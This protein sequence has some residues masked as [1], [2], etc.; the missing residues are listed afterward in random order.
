M[1]LKALN[2]YLCSRGDFN[3]GPL[4]QGELFFLQLSYSGGGR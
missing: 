4:M 1:E 2:R 3:S